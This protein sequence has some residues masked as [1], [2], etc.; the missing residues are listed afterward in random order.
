MLLVSIGGMVVAGVGAVAVALSSDSDS[1]GRTPGD[2]VADLFGAR[3]SD[4]RIVGSAYLVEG[5]DEEA[6]AT[7]GSV[8]PGAVPAYE[9]DPTAWFVA[10]TP[11]DLADQA[12]GGARDDFAGGRVHELSGWLLPAT[13]LQLCGIAARET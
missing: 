5:P 12:A 3:L 8:P 11:S 13:V 2:A 7:R 10:A 9:D 4:A 1:P 6:L